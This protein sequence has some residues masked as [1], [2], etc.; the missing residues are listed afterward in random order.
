MQTW[1][2]LYI[3][4]KVNVVSISMLSFCSGFVCRYVPMYLCIC[5]PP[6]A[7]TDIT[8]AVDP[9]FIVYVTPAIVISAGP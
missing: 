8:V 5:R 3:L 2:F 1:V 4:G 6:D 9:I 7:P